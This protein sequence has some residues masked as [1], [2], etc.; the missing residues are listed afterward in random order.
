[1][2]T[3]QDRPLTAGELTEIRAEL[4][5]KERE[6]EEKTQ[7]LKKLQKDATG[8]Q[9]MS[10]TIQ[11]LEE[12]LNN[13]SLIASRIDRLEESVAIGRESGRRESTSSADINHL[14]INSRDALNLIPDYNGTNMSVFQFTEK[15]EQV[16]VM[17]PREAETNLIHII[18]N[19]LKGLAAKAVAGIK[20][21][22]FDGLTSVLKQAFAPQKLVS[23][24]YGELANLCKKPNEHVIDY[25]ARTRDIIDAIEDGERTERG[26][27][28]T[29]EAKRI[30][31]RAISHFLSGLPSDLQSLV[32]HETYKNLSDVFLKTIACEKAL[33]M[34][35]QKK[36]N[37]MTQLEPRKDVK[38]APTTS[39]PKENRNKEPS[40]SETPRETCRYCKKPGHN[41]SECRTLAFR[42]S[43]QG[44]G[45][46]NGAPK[47][48]DANRSAPSTSRPTM[49][50][51]ATSKPQQ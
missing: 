24:Y 14:N 23:D 38:R 9:V 17:F 50:I 33:A 44:Q 22:D 28:P 27:L 19:K 47:I 32:K 10:S 43:Q 45:N 2:S 7:Q 8:A 46:Y 5:K 12:R 20:F 18:L 37:M 30:E 31:N 35:K 16:R 49:T 26:V 25:I 51:Q 1:M 13:L 15:L 3:E 34:E 36:Q 39:V 21:T 41:I 48:G 40:S 4:A 6:I 11:D 42:K 29:L